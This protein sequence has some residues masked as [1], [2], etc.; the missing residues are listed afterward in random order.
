MIPFM[1][2]AASGIVPSGRLNSNIEEHIE[3]A[4]QSIAQAI[5]LLTSDSWLDT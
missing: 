4:Q 2:Q 1:F 3:L 5:T